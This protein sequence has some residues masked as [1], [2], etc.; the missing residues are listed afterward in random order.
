MYTNLYCPLKCSPTNSIDNQKHILTCSKLNDNKPNV[1]I[2]NIY[3]NLEEQVQVAR[4][5][6]KL[7]RKR[8]KLLEV[9]T[10]NPTR[11]NSN[12]HS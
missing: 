2:E 7:M 1:E 10:N 4:V 9:E 5:L 12:S 8:N 6:S 11:D 3:G